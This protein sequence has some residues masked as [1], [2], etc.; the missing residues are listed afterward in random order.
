[1]DITELEASSLL[2]A[3]HKYE[4][5]QWEEL[6]TFF[7][8]ILHIILL[9]FQERHY[10]Y[11]SGMSLGIDNNSI[12]ESETSPKEIKYAWY[13]NLIKITWLERS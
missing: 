2:E 6:S 5:S 7:N 1:M 10:K 9:T 3:L 11:N 4:G 12:I 13:C 8:V